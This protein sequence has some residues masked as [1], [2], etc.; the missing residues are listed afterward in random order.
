MKNVYQEASDVGE[1]KDKM[2]DMFDVALDHYK[3][4][5]QK[6][7]KLLLKLSKLNKELDELEKEYDILL[8]QF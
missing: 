7:K 4:N 1:Y 3:I 2:S 8:K 5:P 6:S